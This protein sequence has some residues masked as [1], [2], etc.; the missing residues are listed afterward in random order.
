MQSFGETIQG[1]FALAFGLSYLVSGPLG[2]YVVYIEL[3]KGP[4]AFVLNFIIAGI[5]MGGLINFI[6]ST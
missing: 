4:V 6:L 3:D 1:F 2:L 5:P